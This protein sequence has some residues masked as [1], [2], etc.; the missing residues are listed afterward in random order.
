MSEYTGLNIGNQK[1]DFMGQVI[2]DPF[3]MSTPSLA[4]ESL[5][6]FTKSPE[7]AFAASTAGT[8]PGAAGDIG[9]TTLGID[10]DIF[11]IGLGAAQL[12][13]GYLNYKENSEMND[14][15]KAA[16]AQNLE[17]AKT[18]AAATA[19]YRKSYGA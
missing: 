4:T 8:A 13:L 12:G 17:S 15:K 10:N 7:N 18:E 11:G 2:Q 9:N 3:A 6:N 19:A 5:K 14:A 1:L 16:M